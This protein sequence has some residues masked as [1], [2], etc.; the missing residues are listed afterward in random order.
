MTYSLSIHL[1]SFLK[2]I[3]LYYFWP[4]WVFLVARGLFL[5][6]TSGDYS[7]VAVSKL[8]IA[9]VFLVAEHGF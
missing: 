4:R 6:L 2:I 1:I 9:G 8:L 7:L 3:Y 5:V